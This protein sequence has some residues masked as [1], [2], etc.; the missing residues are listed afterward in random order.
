V[1]HHQ[2]EAV[3][4]APLLILELKHPPT[5]ED[6]VQA[7]QILTDSFQP[8]AQVV[9]EE[10]LDPATQ[11]VLNPTLI[12]DF[13]PSQVLDADHRHNVRPVFSPLG[14]FQDHNVSCLMVPKGLVVQQG[15]LLDRPEDLFKMLILGLFQLVLMRVQVE[16]LPL[17]SEV[18]KMLYPTSLCSL[19]HNSV[20]PEEVQPLMSTHDFKDKPELSCREWDE[21][22]SSQPKRLSS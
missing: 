3:V 2:V 4:A 7:A 9:V 13:Q 21:Q 22:D 19:P 1:D 8:R 20:H 16:M 10:I 5:L 17:H 15:P 12:Q 6:L 11:V 14:T 18:A